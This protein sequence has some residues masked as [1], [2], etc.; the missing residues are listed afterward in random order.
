MKKSIANAMSRKIKIY[1]QH[2]INNNTETN[3]NII[4][5]K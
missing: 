1:D 2:N 3:L 4:K 5:C